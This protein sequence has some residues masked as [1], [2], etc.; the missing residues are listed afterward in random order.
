MVD[1]GHRPHRPQQLHRY[2]P[3]PGGREGSGG[4]VLPAERGLTLSRAAEPGTNSFNSTG[5]YISPPEDLAQQCVRDSSLATL[6][7]SP[8]LG[9]LNKAAL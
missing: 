9:E 8:L 1:A 3:G 7:R 2:G 5:S 6:I 4:Q